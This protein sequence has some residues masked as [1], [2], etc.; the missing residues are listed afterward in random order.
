MHPP[1]YARASVRSLLACWLAFSARIVEALSGR[2]RA[3]MA[4][5]GS[6]AVKDAI[7]DLDNDEPSTPGWSESLPL[8][9][10][11]PEMLV[12]TLQDKVEQALR[13]AADAINEDPSGAWAAVTEERVLT[14]FTDLGQEAL[15]RALELRVAA[16]EA[17]VPRRRRARGLWA[18]KFRCM[19][20]A[21]GRWPLP[22]DLADHDMGRCS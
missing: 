2:L 7:L 10:L 13:Q 12:A 16:A 19:L 17:R 20:A 5:V 8:P 21:E 22:E 14:L 15:N 1:G 18:H 6:D 4:D 11:S 9:P 3:T